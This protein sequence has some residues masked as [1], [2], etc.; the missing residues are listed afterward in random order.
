MCFDFLYKLFMK[1]FLNLRIIERNIV[2]NVHRFSCKVP[3]IVFRF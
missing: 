1:T 3:V 2:I